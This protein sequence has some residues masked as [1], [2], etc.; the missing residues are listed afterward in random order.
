LTSGTLTTAVSG[1]ID[2][3]WLRAAPGARYKADRVLRLGPT[4]GYVVGIG[5]GRELLRCALYAPNGDQMVA[6]ARRHLIFPIAQEAVTPECFRDLVC[7]ALTDCRAQ[8]R[9]TASVVGC[10]VAWPTRVSSLT[11][12]PDP[13]ECHSGWDKVDVRELVGDALERSG[14]PRGVTIVNDANAEALAEWRCGNAS[15]AH[16]ALV[17]KLAGGVGAGVV[18]NGELMTGGHGF[19]GELGHVPVAFSATDHRLKIAIEAP[20]NLAPLNPDA[21]CDCGRTGHLQALISMGA[22]VDRLRPGLAREEGS[23]LRA[24]DIINEDLGLELPSGEMRR[25]A[26]IDQVMHQVGALLGRALCGPVGT[27]DPDVVVLRSQF[28]PSQRL[29]HGVQEELSKAMLERPDVRLGTLSEAGRWMGAQGAA[30]HAADLYVMPRVRAH[31]EQE[32]LDD[33]WR[34]PPLDETGTHGDAIIQS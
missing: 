13:L 33:A 5:V 10:G 17:I 28:F 23:Y 12:L 3:G 32:P 21:A 25:S 20:P 11:G 26:L 15:G 30:L 31:C 34:V 24:L 14:F 16:T 2:A 8:L 18:H 19:A 27:L 22:V 7:A 4:A 1:L 6:A 9:E 29:V